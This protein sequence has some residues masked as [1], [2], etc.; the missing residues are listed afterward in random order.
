MRKEKNS[1]DG[2]PPGKVQSVAK[3]RRKCAVRLKKKREK[4]KVIERKRGNVS[5]RRQKRKKK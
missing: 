1:I 5:L 2:N 4:F 3:Q